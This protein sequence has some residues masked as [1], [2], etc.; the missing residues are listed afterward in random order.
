MKVVFLLFKKQFLLDV[1]NNNTNPMS[2]SMNNKN[3]FSK[4]SLNVL[5]TM[6][7]EK[8]FDPANHASNNFIHNTYTLI[9][10]EFLKKSLAENLNRL[11]S[12]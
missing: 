10:S 6:T 9:D 11:K 5:E 4:S 12:K 3:L 8:N 2:N 1:E 7:T